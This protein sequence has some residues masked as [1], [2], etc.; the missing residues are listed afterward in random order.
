MSISGIL[1]ALTLILSCIALMGSSNEAEHIINYSWVYSILPTNDKK[2]SMVYIGLK[3][4]VVRDENGHI[5]DINWSDCGT[6]TYCDKNCEQ[7]G[8]DASNV[9]ILAALISIPLVVLSF[10]RA[11]KVLDKYDGYKIIGVNFAL[12]SFLAF[13][14][15]VGEFSDECYS[16]LPSSHEFLYGPG[17]KVASVGLIFQIV[18]FIIHVGTPMS[19]NRDVYKSDFND[20]EGLNS[21]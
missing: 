21:S 15:A 10:I 17:F 16:H 20:L 1:N 7:V 4:V 13:T 11:S 12:I 9:L 14:I 18:N 5:E 19:L 3:K 6:T 8:K 2:N